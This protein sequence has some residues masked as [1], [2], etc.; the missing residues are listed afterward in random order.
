MD[1]S[2]EYEHVFPG[3]K[4]GSPEWSNQLINS[5]GPQTGT[6]TR[7]S[8]EIPG[9]SGQALVIPREFPARSAGKILHVFPWENPGIL[10]FQWK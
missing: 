4:T 8:R 1:L 5:Q 3:E 10:D 2:S 9:K 7:Y 6:S